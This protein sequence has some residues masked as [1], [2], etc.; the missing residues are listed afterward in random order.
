[1]SGFT[2]G[3]PQT[4]AQTSTGFAFGASTTP[5]APAQQP[6]APL[7]FGTP[8]STTTVTGL[9]IPATT[10][11]APGLTFGTSA[12]PYGAQLTTSTPSLSFGLGTAT[13]RY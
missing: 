4:T 11:T 1:M 12:P 7:T 8:A 5:Q 2:F 3:T 6:A 13:T 10:S 9:S